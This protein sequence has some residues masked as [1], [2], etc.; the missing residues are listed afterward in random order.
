M[1]GSFSDHSSLHSSFLPPSLASFFLSLGPPPIAS[2]PRLQLLLE[3]RE[4]EEEV[5]EE[6][7][8]DARF[9][10]SFHPPAVIPSFASASPTLSFLIWWGGGGFF[11]LKIHQP[12]PT[13]L[14]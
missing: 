2:L 1:S 3:E 4:R 8:E 14:L 7:V 10:S 5:E 11:H 6:E 13:A 12:Q 9:V